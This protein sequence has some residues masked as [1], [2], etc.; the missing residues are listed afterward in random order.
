MFLFVFIFISI[1]SSDVYAFLKHIYTKHPP[2]I[3]NFKYDEKAVTAD[4]VKKCVMKAITHYHPDKQV[5]FGMEWKILCEEIA[6]CLTRRYEQ[7]FKGT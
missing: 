5:L 2:K 3:G 1:F 4:N 7:F 6:K